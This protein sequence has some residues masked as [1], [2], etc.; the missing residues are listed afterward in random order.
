MV[1]LIV[2]SNVFCSNRIVV[3]DVYRWVLSCLSL[4]YIYKIYFKNIM[5][6]FIERKKNKLIIMFFF[7][8]GRVELNLFFLL[9]GLGF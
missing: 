9:Y 6:E 1:G 3:K 5:F 8:F 4:W 7:N 2:D